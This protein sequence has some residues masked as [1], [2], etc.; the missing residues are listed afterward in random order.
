MKTVALSL[1]LCAA[2][3]ASAVFWSGWSIR[4]RLAHYY[5]RRC[6][7][8]AWRKRFPSAT[9]EEI[10]DFLRL[11]VA[12]FLLEKK[13]ALSFSPDDKVMDVYRTIY[14]SPIMADAL[15]TVTFARECQRN[16][17]VDITK[18]CEADPTL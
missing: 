6:A 12:A 10:R 17:G 9:K 11:F 8:R 14:P 2:L 13:R 15:E 1:I 16:F 4:R 3:V 7:G 5:S 18:D